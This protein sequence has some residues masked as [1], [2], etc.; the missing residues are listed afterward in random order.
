MSKITETIKTKVTDS[1]SALGF[2]EAKV[3]L[4]H[5]TELSFGD[6]SC[7]VAMALAKQINKNPLEIAEMLVRE[8]QKDL[9]DILENVEAVKP[10]FINFYLSKK[11]FTESTKEIAQ[12]GSNF[13]KSEILAGKSIVV[14]FTDPNPFKQFHI[15][16]L[17]SNAIGESLSRI[18]EYSGA[19]VIR[20]NYQ[21]DVGLHVAKCIWGILQK[22]RD[23][24]LTSSSSNEEKVKF[25]GD[26]YVAGNTAYE[27]DADAKLEIIAINKKV[28]ERSDQT[29]N[30]IYDAGR[31]ISLQH[32]EEIYKK[33][34]STFDHYFFESE[35]WKIGLA[36]VKAHIDDGIFKISDGATIF[37]GEEYGLH[38]RVF[39]NSQGLTTY[40]AK[41]LGLCE[42]K[43]QRIN[44]FD[45]S[46][47]ITALEQKE[48]FKVVN[49]AFSLINPDAVQTTHIGHGFLRLATGKMSS[50]KGNVITGE[51]LLI[52]T[53]EL[54]MEKINDREL[55]S[56][57]KKII[58]EATAVAAIKYTILRQSPGKDII[59]DPEKSISFEGDSGPY[60]QYSYTR[61]LSVLEKAKG[62]GIEENTQSHGNT[63][64]DLEKILYRFPEVVELS[65]HELAPSY[66]VTYLTGLAS[67]F[68]SFY[69][70]NK[71]I[72]T[73][74][75]ESG[76]RLALTN[77]FAQVMKNGL[78][79]LAIKTLERM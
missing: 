57:D 21:G 45:Q 65:Y 72:D 48:Y 79:L 61:A 30:A 17:M 23:Y 19:K 39:I 77:N 42:L 34:G 36:L 29:I 44:Q 25:L 41:D 55:D 26:C 20:A 69:A 10:G 5:P 63:V 16:H 74:N 58:G 54:A 59:F 27:E 46:I 52:D 24:L 66:I 37:L 50:R 76:Y 67:V 14:E 11:F 8:L 4:E 3:R 32:F 2:P 78:S 73:S 6:Y 62:E 40:E 22:E 38:T 12:K 71:I 75:P 33:L 49:K 31:S 43:T 56:N 68:N 70:Q 7:N 18:I 9:G 60:L 47:I 28:Y 13:G 51:S 64:Y 15:G 53:E 1:L 35:S